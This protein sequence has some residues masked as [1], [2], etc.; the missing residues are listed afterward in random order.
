MSEASL[1][2]SAALTVASE[3]S[4]AKLIR[5]ARETSIPWIID[6][7]WQQG[8]IVIVH[9]LEEEF[10]S[11]FSYQIAEAIAA[12]S[13]LLRTWQIPR[14]R[15]V[16][17]FETEM[18]DLEVGKRLGKMF[19]Q[20]DWPVGLIV[21]DAVLMTEF[22]KK[23]TRET[24]MQCL[25]RWMKLN[26]IEILVWDTV[27]SILATG[28]PN[29]EKSVSQFFDGLALL[30]QKGTLVVRHDLKPSKDTVQRHTNQLVRGS[31]RLVE[32]ASTVIHLSRTDKAQNRVRFLVGKLRNGAKPDPME[33]WFDAGT[34][35]LTP[36]PPVAAMLEDGPRT[37][38]DLIKCIGERFALKERAI[39]TS[40]KELQPLLIESQRGHNR[41][42]ALNEK[43]IPSSDSP[44]T[45][46]WP[47]LRA[48]E[49]HQ[50]EMQ[51]CSSIRSA[52]VDQTPDGQWVQ[53]IEAVTIAS[54]RK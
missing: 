34:F 52:S 38:Q 53:A 14:P 23:L 10:K 3:H 1:A 25:E 37:R 51:G 49:T 5:R 19:P 33:L 8:G 16:G 44:V 27:N 11:I 42:F 15:R 20:G 43:A 54:D 50:G 45:R 24:K 46:W 22:R 32:D 47:L 36:L 4:I 2:S 35:R 40:L 30:P 21:S 41:V 28:E 18:D 17:I 7:L 9:S 39:D 6:G 26:E 31:N 48:P 29:S 12:S 13:P